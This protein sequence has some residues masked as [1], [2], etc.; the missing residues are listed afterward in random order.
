MRLFNAN[1]IFDFDQNDLDQ[2][3]FFK[4]E[5]FLDYWYSGF[6]KPPIKTS[7]VSKMA[8]NAI[9]TVYV[10][11]YLGIRCFTTFALCI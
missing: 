6:K 11:V 5:R 4:V 1:V 10:V 2:R 3:S 9:V 7:N 8:V